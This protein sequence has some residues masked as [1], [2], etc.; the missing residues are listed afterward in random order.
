MRA[1]L[2]CALIFL[3]SCMSHEEAMLQLKGEE[4]ACAD[5]RLA[6]ILHNEVEYIACTNVALERYFQS[7]NIS[8]PHDRYHDA[9]L[10]QFMN[11]RLT[12]AN[13]VDSKRIP[14]SQAGQRY[15]QAQKELEKRHEQYLSELEQKQRL[16]EAKL[17]ER[18]RLVELCVNQYEANQPRKYDTHCFGGAVPNGFASSGYANCVTEERRNYAPAYVYNQCRDDASRAVGLPIF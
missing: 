9:N 18:A 15:E 3:T 17:A 1:I 5:E 10:Q 8:W 11:E 14:S 2:F 12:I 4:A 16:H 7:Y 6:G 13:E